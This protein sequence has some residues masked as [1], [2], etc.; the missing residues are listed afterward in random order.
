M[1]I[2]HALLRRGHEVLVVCPPVFLP[3]VQAYGLP[4]VGAGLD[5]LRSEPER[6]FPPFG[7]VA[8]GERTGWLIDHVYADQAPRRLLP[9]MNTIFD[10][11]QPQVILR[12][13]AE[14]ASWLVAEQRGIPH[15]SFGYG[16]GLM[17][18]DRRRMAPGVARLR[19]E[20]GLPPDPREFAPPSYRPS[21]SEANPNTHHL[22]FVP[23][24]DPDRL[25]LPAWAEAKPAHP[26]VVVTL[27]NNYNR[28]PGLLEGIAAALAGLEIEIVFLVG[29]N[30]MPESL[31]DLPA[32]ARALSYL[33]LSRLLPTSSLLVSHAGFNTIMTAACAGVPMVMVPIDSDQPTHA[34]RCQVLGLAEML[35]AAE[36][37]ARGL[38]RAVPAMLADAGRSARIATFRQTVEALPDADHAVDLLEGLAGADR[39]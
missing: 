28:V 14:F 3:T 24:D 30:R 33:P 13:Q 17:E 25:A 4:A 26:R 36:P 5:W 6:F 35:D 16:L 15:V 29:R 19:A 37:L 12:D 2:A 10:R 32:G 7:N 38:R 34:R 1:P 8:P 21:D 23:S 18:Q 20:V 22:R 39:A 31:G 9:E 27:G 11:W